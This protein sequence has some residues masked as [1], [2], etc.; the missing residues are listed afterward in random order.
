MA[1]S[2]TSGE[3]SGDLTVTDASGRMT[4]RP[5]AS[6]ADVG[7]TGKA[8]LASPRDATPVIGVE[9]SPLAPPVVAPSPVVDPPRVGES[10][11][12][13]AADARLVLSPAIGARVSGPDTTAWMSGSLRGAIP[14]GLWAFGIWARLDLPVAST[15]R[16]SPWFSMSSVSIWLGVWPA[17]AV[18]P[19]S[20]SQ[21]ALPPPGAGSKFRHL[22]PGFR[23]PDP[24]TAER[25]TE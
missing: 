18:Q 25:V 6:P 17:F 2:L 23:G 16:Q 10:R 11:P 1:L 22:H 14:V 20:L 15:H 19:L 24:E 5:V 21:G 12:P 13:P 8:L 7:P 4:T 3:A 9:A